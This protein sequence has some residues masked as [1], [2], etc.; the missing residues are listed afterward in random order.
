LL[1]SLALTRKQA[2]E[3]LETLR[4][5]TDAAKAEAVNQVSVI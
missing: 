1:P 5:A 4:E 3:F 2:D